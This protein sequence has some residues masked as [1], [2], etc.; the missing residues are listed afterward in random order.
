MACRRSAVRSRLAPP[1]SESRPDG[2]LSCFRRPGMESW[3]QGQGRIWFMKGKIGLEEHF[4][5]EDTIND[6][7]GFFPDAIW[8]ELKSRLFDLHDK[9]LRL[10]DQHGVE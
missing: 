7:A 6:S 5:I 8:E 9:R 1:N 10:M 4:A 3:L 2:R